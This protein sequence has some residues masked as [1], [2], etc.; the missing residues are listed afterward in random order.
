MVRRQTDRQTVLGPFA[1]GEGGSNGRDALGCSGSLLEAWEISGSA[2]A[3]AWASLGHSWGEAWGV[4]CQDLFPPQEFSF[5][6][7]GQEFRPLDCPNGHNGAHSQTPGKHAPVEN[8]GFLLDT[9][10]LSATI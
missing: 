10:A 8:D 4:G 5:V 3:L 9:R 2:I 7:P 1:V 6:A